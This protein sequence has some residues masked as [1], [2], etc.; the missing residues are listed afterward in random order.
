MAI[1]E[2]GRNETNFPNGARVVAVTTATSDGATPPNLS[3][4]ATA[5]TITPAKDGSMPFGYPAAFP[6]ATVNPVP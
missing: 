5:M 2:I 6:G 4:I 3:D 1:I